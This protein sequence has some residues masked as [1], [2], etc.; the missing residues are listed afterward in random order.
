MLGLPVA[1]NLFES[2]RNVSDPRSAL[3]V[4]LQANNCTDHA[5]RLYMLRLQTVTSWD[6][7]VGLNFGT[8]SRLS[9]F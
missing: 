3:L 7:S 8:D 1:Q 2:I 9:D 6:T 4:G 5:S